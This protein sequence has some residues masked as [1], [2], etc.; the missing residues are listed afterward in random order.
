MC[1][2]LT[3]IAF[4]FSW[5]C[6]SWFHLMSFEHLKSFLWYNYKSIQTIK[7]VADLLTVH[8]NIIIMSDIPV[9]TGAIQNSK[10]R[11]WMKINTCSFPAMWEKKYHQYMISDNYWK[12]H[13][14]ILIDSLAQ[15]SRCHFDSA[16]WTKN[17]L[18]I[19]V[20]LCFW[21]PQIHQLKFLITSYHGQ[22]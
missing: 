2:T 8:H 14:Y 18:K 12:K 4:S 9:L 11:N 6:G 13:I 22:I 1:N 21:L 3:R 5:F 15:S 10:L 20:F 19:H 7:I 16:Q 17:I